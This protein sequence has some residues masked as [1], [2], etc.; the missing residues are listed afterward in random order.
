[1]NKKSEPSD[2][3][4]F[5]TFNLGASDYQLNYYVGSEPGFSSVG[6][7]TPARANVKIRE[8]LLVLQSRGGSSQLTAIISCWTSRKSIGS[9]ISTNIRIFHLSFRSGGP[10][11]VT[12][13][14]KRPK[15]Y[16]FFNNSAAF[17]FTQFSC[18]SVGQSRFYTI[19]NH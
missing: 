3:I 18:H 19:R 11:L 1:M 16:L 5:R 15:I 14:W 8:L 6:P 2:R 12:R 7:W 4:E 9:C 13:G 17:G 10:F